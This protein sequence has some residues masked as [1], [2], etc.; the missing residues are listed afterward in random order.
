MAW[1]NNVQ[2]GQSWHGNQ[3]KGLRERLR[4]RAQTQGRARA[5][6]VWKGQACSGMAKD[7]LITLGRGMELKAWHDENGNAW[8]GNAWKPG[9]R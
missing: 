6:L 8:L 3:G 7:R 2:L 4:S 1:H 5:R 9:T